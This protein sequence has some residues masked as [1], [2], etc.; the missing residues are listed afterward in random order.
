[1]GADAS[2]YSRSRGLWG[3]LGYPKLKQSQYRGV[4]LRDIADEME[5][6]LSKEI[7]NIPKVKANLLF[8]YKRAEFIKSHRAAEWHLWGKS[9]FRYDI[10]GEQQE[11]LAHIAD[12]FG[13]EVLVLYAAPAVVTM[14]DLLSAKLG[15]N[16]I[17]STNFR[18]AVDLI[19]HHRNTY[20][21]PGS[22]SIA[23]SEPERFAPFSLLRELRNLDGFSFENPARF[24]IEFAQGV[25]EVLVSDTLFGDYFLR[26]AERYNDAG[27]SLDSLYF[28][29]VSMSIFRELTGVQWVVATAQ[30][31]QRLSSNKNVFPNRY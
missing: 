20:V 13:V 23:C 8:Q 9:Y 4:E 11:L 2:G 27:V 5:L 10:Y 29:M 21:D 30:N 12:K 28:S 18:P 25:R 7:R 15:R 19:G 3:T 14:D 31:E 6:R 24:F 16:I 17:E 1:M 22:F 26:E